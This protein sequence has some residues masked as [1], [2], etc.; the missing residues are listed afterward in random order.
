ME[1]LK[2]KMMHRALLLLTERKVDA[3]LGF[4]RGTIPMMSHPILIR[5]PEKADQLHWD[6]FCSTNL[7]TYLPQ[8]KERI[9]I[10]AKGCDSRNIV[11][12]ILENQ[13]KREQLYI[14]GVPC[15]GMLDRRKVQAELNGRELLG[16]RETSQHLHLL[17]EGFMDSLERSSYLQENCA[18]CT[19]RNAAIHDELLAEPVLEQKGV[20]RYEDVR[21]I[22]AMTASE[23]WSYF[24]ELLAPCIRCYACRNACPMCYCPVCFVD[25][26]MPQWL[27]KSIDPTDT[28]TFHFLRA[29]HLAGR[30]TDCGNCERACPM[31]IKVRQL[32]KKLEKDIAE[33]Y[34]YEAGLSLD[35]PPP[36]DTYRPDDPQEFIK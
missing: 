19:H 36:L 16:V 20:D 5:H 25:E 6:S 7:A 17:G 11:L 2:E 12:Q 18:I 27:G 29:Y 23:R 3:V 4:Q 9:A 8:R 13:I 31:S 28:K 24:E 32:T 14:I 35:Q 22:E 21:A 10:F 33:L 34:D 30:C 15:Q 1:S 26:S